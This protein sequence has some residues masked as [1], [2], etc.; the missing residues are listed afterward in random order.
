MDGQLASAHNLLALYISSLQSLNK[1]VDTESLSITVPEVIGTGTVLVTVQYHKLVPPQIDIN[2][3]GCLLFAA[4]YQDSMLLQRAPASAVL[5]GT[6]QLNRSLHA[7]LNCSRP[8]IQTK[9]WPKG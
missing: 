3:G 6:G 5:W 9:P 1:P 7:L 2:S 4:Y 8:G